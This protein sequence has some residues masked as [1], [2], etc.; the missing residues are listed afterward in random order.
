MNT[1]RTVMT[2]AALSFMIPLPG[3]LARAGGTP[4]PQEMQLTGVVRDF[5]ERT[6]SGGHPDFEQK[7][8]SGFGHY[9]GNIAQ[10]LDGDG[11]PVFIGGGHKVRSQ[12]KNARWQPILPALYDPALGD[13]RGSYRG[14]DDGGIESAESFRQWYR[15]TPGKNLSQPLNITLT[16]IGGT[17]EQPIYSYENHSFFP[18]DHQLYGNSGGAPDHNFHFTFELKTEF[19]YLAGTNQVF[20]FYGDDD[21][22]VFINGKLVID[23]G[24]VH[25]SVNQVVELDRL[26]LEDGKTYPLDFFFAERHRTQS[27]FR[28][29]TTLVLK[30]TDL[31][32]VSA[33]YD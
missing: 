5:I 31:P 28:I 13:H 29:D 17:D 32:T 4:P 1:R 26:G 11:K 27:N 14:T 16:R 22:W 24:G 15:D 30:N 19:T 23:I 6:K 9:M 25:S 2:A 8:D 20:S 33:A 12:W 3:L 7:P 21:V 18:I 10:Y